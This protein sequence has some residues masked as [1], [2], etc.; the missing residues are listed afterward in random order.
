MTKKQIADCAALAQ[1]KDYP[2]A[3]D[4]T[5][6]HGLALPEY[7]DGYANKN[8]IA[9]FMAYHCAQFN[10]GWDNAEFGN[11]AYL[12]KKKVTMIGS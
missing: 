7:R 8:Q 1:S 3:V 5:C 12:L 4:D 2:S 11:L 9:Y 10:G 6:L